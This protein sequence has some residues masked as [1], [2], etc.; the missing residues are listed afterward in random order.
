MECFKYIKT[1]FR[2]I[3]EEVRIQDSLYYLI[4]PDGYMYW[5]VRKGMHGQKISARLAFDNIVKTTVTPQIFPPSDNPLVYGIIRPI[6]RCLPFVL[7]IFLSKT[8]NHMKHIN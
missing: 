3:P 4:E 2:L 7:A 8:M 1:Y 6:P 5:E